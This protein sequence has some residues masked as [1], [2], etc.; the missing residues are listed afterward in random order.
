MSLEMINVVQQPRRHENL[1]RID[2]LRARGQIR[3]GKQP[4]R[5]AQQRHRPPQQ[6]VGGELLAGRA[7]RPEW[8]GVGTEEVRVLCR[9]AHDLHD[10]METGLLLAGAEEPVGAE[11]GASRSD[12]VPED[13]GERRVGVDQVPEVGGGGEA[14]GAGE[15]SLVLWNGAG[16][17]GAGG[18]DDEE[19]EVEKGNK[20]LLYTEVFRRGS[21]SPRKLSVLV[22]P[23]KVADERD[24][25]D[26]FS[27][28]I[29]QRNSQVFYLVTI[30]WSTHFSIITERG[31]PSIFHLA[32]L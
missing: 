6:R 25:E 18:K 5:R 7:A 19:K 28:S 30:S 20:K 14:Q 21:S 16:P 8:G 12:K 17:V 32:L 11:P 22:R 24:I 1:E 27:G 26:F 15:V 10:R 23:E 29:Y 9:I 4:R 3:P 13:W 31:W 2:P